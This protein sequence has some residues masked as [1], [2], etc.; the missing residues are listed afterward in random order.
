MSSNSVIDQ[1]REE[2]NNQNDPSNKQLALV[3]KVANQLVHFG[4]IIIVGTCALYTCR[5]SQTNLLPTLVDCAPYTSQIPSFQTNNAFVETNVNIVAGD[6]ST[7]MI[8]PVQENLDQMTNHSFFSWL[9]NC[10]EGEK[11]SQFSLYFSSIMQNILAFNFSAVNRVYQMFNNFLPETLIILLLPYVVSFM[12]FALAFLDGFY[13]IYLW[14]AKLPA[15]CSQKNGNKWEKSSSIFE[16][17]NWWKIFVAVILVLFGVSTFITVPFV[18]VA[19]AYTFFFPL[20]LKTQVQS[21]NKPK[22]YGPMSLFK[23]VLKFKRHI[24]M[25]ILS[26][27]L[28]NDTATLFGAAEATSVVVVCIALFFFTGI[29][30]EYKPTAADG[31]TGGLVSYEQLEKTCGKGTEVPIS[32]VPPVPSAPYPPDA[33]GIDSNSLPPNPVGFYNPNSVETSLP[34]Q[35]L[36][37]PSAPYASLQPQSAN[38]YPNST[39]RNP[40]GMQGGSWKN[41]SRKIRT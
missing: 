24:F 40:S 38:Q 4:F 21:D 18:I 30:H 32:E 12:Y 6:A 28:L 5:S 2:I 16:F 11:S 39:I 22:K 8:F 3:K 27:L 10:A 14:F 23:D 7:K 41:R 36:P 19:V 35:P 17:W 26:F 9:R 13:F 1:K 29:F 34:Q 33:Y 31:V 37:I 20:T 25:Y 15:F